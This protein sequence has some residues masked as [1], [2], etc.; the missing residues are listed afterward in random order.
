MQKALFG[1]LLFFSIISSAQVSGEK[2][3]D[4]R[5]TLEDAL[6]MV[7][8][9]FTISFSYNPKLLEGVYLEKSLTGASID[10]VLNELKNQFPLSVLKIEDDSYVLRAKTDSLFCGYIVEES[11]GKPIEGATVTDLKKTQ[12]T[13][14]NTEGYFQLQRQTSIDTLVASYLGFELKILPITVFKTLGCPRFNLKER[15]YKLNEVIV[16]DYLVAGIL[17]EKDGS[18]RI[19]PNN[20][21]ILSGLAEPDVLQNTQLLPGIESPNE[22]AA[23]LYIRGGTPDQN[24]ILWDGIK[25]YNTDHFFGSF[26]MFNPY[27][28]D[29]I[30]VSR[31]GTAANYGDRV[32]G[33]VDVSTSDR[34]PEKTSGGFGM[35]FI[36]ADGFLSIPLS[37]KVGIQISGRRALTD[38]LETVTFS[39]FSGKAFQNTSLDTSTNSFE[40]QF[41][42]S[43]ENFSFW[44][45]HVKL[46]AKPTDRDLIT[47][48][49]IITQNNLDYSFEDI[50][51][52]DSIF[53]RLKVQNFGVSSSWEHRI[54]SKIETKAN[55]YYSDYS[56][57]Y[58][59][60]REN[61]VEVF[62][63]EKNNRLKEF[64]I[65]LDANWKISDQVSLLN[66]YQFFNTNVNY[67]LAT[68]FFEES[69]FGTIN[70]HAFFHQLNYQAKK[71]YIQL[72]F[73][74]AYYSTLKR[75][76]I[77]PRVFIEKEIFKDFRLK[78]SGEIKNQSISQIIEFTTQDFGLDN[79]I[80]A[81]ADTGDIPPLR[82]NQISTGLFWHKNSWRL[83]LDVYRKNI[84]GLTSLTRGFQ[85][86]QD[87]LT[88][89]ESVTKGIDVLVKKGFGNYSTWLGYT[90]SI[91][92]FLFAELNNGIAFSGNNDIRHS[93]TWSH[94]Y[95][96]KNIQ[97]SM[98]WKYRTGIP[99]TQATTFIN[100]ENNTEIGFE[101][102]NKKRF[103]DYHRMDFSALYDVKLSSKHQAKSLKLG[104]S[105]LNIY[106]RKNPLGR[107]FFLDDVEDENGEFSEQIN[108]ITRLSLGF[109]PNLVAR[110]NF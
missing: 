88:N 29:Q 12:G 67:L 104:C 58:D 66:G 19:N 100:E 21:E 68:S 9:R 94:S 89:G 53:D 2:S 47:A 48:S 60:L 55:A 11:T 51:F 105:F 37:K 65:S 108:E 46:V 42:T 22:T 57:N 87:I 45:S 62:D 110:F 6:S 72:G 99:F 8:E 33:V 38:I 80:W 93:F 32:S 102:L 63:V 109:T 95:K 13:T 97:L 78:F 24:L 43:N 49:T 81:Q 75:W 86:A 77:E 54:N 69:G 83:D 30:K 17:K 35:N 84:D 98:G 5:I 50:N 85:A 107:T 1:L 103:S 20:L 74:N 59:G 90:Y 79:Q 15:N 96:I 25:M 91:T 40:P 3:L 18:I 31:G 16:N 61:D 14:T 36:S 7:E 92:D 76:F 10:E 71:W 70:S 41:T 27:T 52:V 64:G 28:I 73:R 34:I 39:N 106:N 4:S 82:S 56:F 23:G 26:S 101:D 44:D